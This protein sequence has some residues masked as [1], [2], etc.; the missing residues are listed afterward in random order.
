MEEIMKKRSTVLKLLVPAAAAALLLSACSGGADA[1]ANGEEPAFRTVKEG[2][3]TVAPYSESAPVVTRDS[4][5][6]GGLTGDFINGFAEE[7]GLTVEILKADFSGSLAATQQ[8]RAD[9]TPYIYYTPERSKT[10]FFTAP[11]FVLPSG[12]YT[13]E[14]FDYSGVESLTGT[15]VGAVV[16]QVW[17]PYIRD[18]FGDDGVLF[19]T[20]VDAETALVNG[21]ID[22]YVNSNFQMLVAPFS[23]RDDVVF[24]ELAEGD[25]D[26]P[27]EV[28]NTYSYN[29]VSCSNP[30]LADAMDEYQRGLVE[31]GDWIGLYD[32]NDFPEESRLLDAA[33]IVQPAQGCGS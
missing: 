11:N 24:H 28:I 23:D 17:E 7:N 12:V 14:G 9:I 18:A 22:A 32:A 15:K 26:M 3:L 16:G 13:M 10:V 25:L 27:T 29:V 8:G 4:G 31:S 21:Q 2:V 1:P 30:D 6:L 33:D 19:Q 20:A 5:S